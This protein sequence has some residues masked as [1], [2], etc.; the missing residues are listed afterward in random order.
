MTYWF[1]LP[2]FNLDGRIL[3]VAIR[4]L[5]RLTTGQSSGKQVCGRTVIRIVFSF[6][7]SHKDKVQLSRVTTDCI[8]QR[9]SNNTVL[10]CSVGVDGS[11]RIVAGNRNN[12]DKFNLEN[13]G[14][15]DASNAEF[16]TSIPTLPQHHS[17][18]LS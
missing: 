12:N 9:F 3:S 11:N 4:R 17:L 15:F 14:N 5:S 1:R 2:L 6:A 16:P 13:D 18:C 10:F 7:H 8:S